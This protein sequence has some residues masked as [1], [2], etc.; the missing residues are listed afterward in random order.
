MDYHHLPVPDAYLREGL[1]HDIGGTRHLVKELL[2][3]PEPPYA[4]V[5][6][7]DARVTPICHDWSERFPEAY[8]VEIQNWIYASKEGRVDGPNAWD[9]YV[10]QIAAKCASKA[11]DTQTSVEIDIPEMPDFYKA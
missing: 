8:N 3:L 10:A 1:Y 9:G 11:R 4:M 7:N 5:R 6:T 2:N